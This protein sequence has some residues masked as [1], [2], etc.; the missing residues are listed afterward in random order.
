MVQSIQRLEKKKEKETEEEDVGEV[1]EGEKRE[2]LWESQS[3][4][5]MVMRCCSVNK[6]SFVKEE[7]WRARR[8]M[9]KNDLVAE[10]DENVNNGGERE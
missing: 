6:W 7:G 4:V 8:K 1:G 3:R 9:T 5:C 10:R 2:D